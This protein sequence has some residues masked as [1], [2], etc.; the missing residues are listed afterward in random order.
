MSAAARTAPE[1]LLEG[2]G[3]EGPEESALL[4]AAQPN[5]SPEVLGHACV[6]VHQGLG[7]RLAGGRGVAARCHG[8][9][10]CYS[11]AR[12]FLRGYPPILRYPKFVP[13]AV[14]WPFGRVRVDGSL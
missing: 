4:E 13:G 7:A 1:M 2:L 11:V 6:Q 8:R 12:A 10:S 5:A 14:G 3:Y 9:S